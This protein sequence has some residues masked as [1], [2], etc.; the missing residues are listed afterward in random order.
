MQLFEKCMDTAQ[1]VHCFIKKEGPSHLE[2]STEG[3]KSIFNAKNKLLSTSVEAS[4]GLG[5]SFF[6][7]Q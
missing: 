3:L 7:K 6:T 5:L 4:K 2:A 1:K